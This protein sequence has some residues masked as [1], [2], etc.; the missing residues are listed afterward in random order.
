MPLIFLGMSTLSENAGVMRTTL[1]VLVTCG[2]AGLAVGAVHGWAL[3][4]LLR[5]H[6][7]ATSV[8]A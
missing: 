6:H 5:R 7:A 4:R 8:V 1:T 3:L 2:A